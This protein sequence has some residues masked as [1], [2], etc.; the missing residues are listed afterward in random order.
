MS[1][2]VG[3]YELKT[4]IHPTRPNP[5]FK[6]FQLN[7]IHQPEVSGWVGFIGFVGW[8]HT[9]TVLLSDGSLCSF[10]P[11]RRCTWIRGRALHFRFS[12]LID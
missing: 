4:I 2:L 11:Y 5:K 3:S 1:D 7:P 8:M 6:K 12:L 10:H 9:P